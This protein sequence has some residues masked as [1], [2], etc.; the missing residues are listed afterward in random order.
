MQINKSLGS[1]MFKAMKKAL[2]P[3]ESLLA[4]I[5]STNQ[6]SAE[7]R[8]EATR[9]EKEKKKEEKKQTG[10]LEGLFQ[11][12]KKTKEQGGFW[13][14]LKNN[15]G[16]ILIALGLLMTP[17]KTLVDGFTWAKDYFQTHTWKEIGTDIAKTIFL[18]FAGKRIAM[19]GAGLA[20]GFLT[21]KL[22]NLF[23]FKPSNLPA[24]SGVPAGSRIHKPGSP[25][26]EKL[27][28]MRGTTKTPSKI[29]G[30]KLPGSPSMFGK[31]GQMVKLTGGLVGKV[32]LPAGV[33]FALFDS[34]DTFSKEGFQKGMAHAVESF[35]I[36]LVPREAS[37][38]VFKTVEDGV[39]EAATNVTKGFISAS[40]EITDGWKDLKNFD[41]S[42]LLDP[43]KKQIAD[44]K[45]AAE[46]K[47]KLINFSYVVLFPNNWLNYLKQLAERY[48]LNSSES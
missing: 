10:F 3:T 2:Q 8:I 44:K 40:N 9:A 21:D 15:W 34:K 35:T 47:A 13:N 25:K 27:A 17:L 31:M 37:E 33:A 43:I 41:Y 30:P 23:N 11:Q 36:G 18:Y 24:S 12:G 7:Q 48:S 5:V 45:K 26:A 6:I 46:E 14:F 22:K 28:R 19:L 42:T 29:P 16:K 39:K 4:A 32:A 38:K 20:A 1:S